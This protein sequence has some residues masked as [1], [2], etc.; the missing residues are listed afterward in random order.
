MDLVVYIVRVPFD[1][2]DTS[3]A[4]LRRSSPQRKGLFLSVVLLHFY[5]V[6]HHTAL[7]NLKWASC[8]FSGSMMG[9]EA[10]FC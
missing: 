6:E 2:C 4:L 3:A 1:G 7:L 5:A 8:N 9:I 10:V